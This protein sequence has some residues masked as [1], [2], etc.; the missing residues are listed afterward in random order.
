MWLEELSDNTKNEDQHFDSA[1]DCYSL[2]DQ[3]CV[4]TQVFE[5]YLQC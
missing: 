5:A 3:A 2:H 4:R 1:D